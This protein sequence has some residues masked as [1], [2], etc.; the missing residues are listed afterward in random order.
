MKYIVILIDPYSDITNAHGTFEDYEAA[1]KWAVKHA[2]GREYHIVQLKAVDY[3][4]R[5]IMKYV[6]IV[7]DLSSGIQ[8]V[9]GPFEDRESANQWASVNV[10]NQPHVIVPIT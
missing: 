5:T 9:H 10:G 7:G 3:Y 6:I 8:T 1:W 2:S 4:R